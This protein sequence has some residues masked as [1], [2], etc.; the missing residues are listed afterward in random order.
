MSGVVDHLTRIALG[1]LEGTHPDRDAVDP[2]G[3]NAQS[4]DPQHGTPGH[5]LEA[6]SPSEDRRGPVITG[7]GSSW[8]A[9]RAADPACLSEGLGT[10]IRRSLRHVQDATGVGGRSR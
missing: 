9:R 5:R 2:D 4:G 3:V 1:G 7:V 6:E 8:T 10:G